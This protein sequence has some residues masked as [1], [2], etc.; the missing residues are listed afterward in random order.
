MRAAATAILIGCFSSA[1][2]IGM[3]TGDF[4]PARGPHGVHA[5]VAT[6]NGVFRGELIELR[7]TGV[8]LLAEHGTAAAPGTKRLRL[9]PFTSIARAE[10][11]QLGSGVRLADGRPPSGRVRERLRLLSR[12]PYGMSSAVEGALLKAYGQDAFAGVER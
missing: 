8:V 2:A 3:H 5:T 11:E 12:F 7:D 6:P 1:C 4:K 9:I 10:F